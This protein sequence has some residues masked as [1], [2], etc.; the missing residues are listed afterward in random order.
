M[1]G[2]SLELKS[3]HRDTIPSSV[4]PRGQPWARHLTLLSLTSYPLK[5]E[6]TDDGLIRLL[7][8]SG[9]VTL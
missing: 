6:N 4:L 1:V 8:V 5:N 7:G 9:E 3:T 2:G